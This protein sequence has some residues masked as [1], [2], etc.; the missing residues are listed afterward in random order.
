M[1]KESDQAV[2]KKKYKW[3]RTDGLSFSLPKK[4]KLKHPSVIY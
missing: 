4:C 1:D 3:A 2:Q